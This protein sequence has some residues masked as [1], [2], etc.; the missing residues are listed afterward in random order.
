M[1]GKPEGTKQ[2]VR[3]GHRWVNNIKMVL[4]DIEWNGIDLLDLA[5]DRDQWRS[6]GSTVMNLRVP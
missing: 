3:P 6:L 2:L 4:R 5:Q 1:V